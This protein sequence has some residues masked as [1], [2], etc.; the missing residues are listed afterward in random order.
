MESKY[1]ILPIDKALFSRYSARTD[2]GM[3]IRER[4]VQNQANPTAAKSTSMS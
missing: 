3:R 1:T 2:W 4:G